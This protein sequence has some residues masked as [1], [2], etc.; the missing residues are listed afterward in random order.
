MSAESLYPID[1]VITWVDGQDPNHLRKLNEY[2]IKIGGHR[3]RT[4]DP[5]RFHNDGEVTYCVV[6]LLKYAPWLRYIYIVTDE[7]T[8][9]IFNQLKGTPWEYKV[10]LID[11][12]DIFAGFEQVLP[13]F[14]IRTIMT[15]LWRIPELAEHFIFFND[16]VVLIQPVSPSNFFHDNGIVVR[17]QWKSLHDRR[18][19]AKLRNIW[20]KYVPKTKKQKLRERALHSDGQKNTARMLGFIDEYFFLEHSPH[21]WRKSVVKNFYDNNPVLFE[22]NIIPKLRTIDQFLGDALA[23]FLEIKSGSALIDE[24]M[25][26]TEVDPPRQTEDY[27]K[28][29]I[30][31]A[32]RESSY[33]FACI[34]SIEKANPELRQYIFDWLDRRIGSLENLRNVAN[35]KVD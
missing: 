21:P 4:A 23:S 29:I 33:A 32:D 7:Q 22:K 12:K 25:K 2:I 13:T 8:P 16:D 9:D 1:A 30:E 10:K 27:V 15:V 18:L 24:T 14:N 6:S 5:T 3:P 26:V 19:K 17:G 35:S 11:H 20:F 28:S 34:Q 31:R